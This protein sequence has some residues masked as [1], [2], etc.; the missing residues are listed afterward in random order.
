MNPPHDVAAIDVRLLV[1]NVGGM[2]ATR[3]PSVVAQEPDCDIYGFVETMLTEEN[4]GEVQGLL[5]GYDARHCVRPRP[6]RGRPH[7]G[8]TVFVKRF[9]PLNMGTG[10]TV[11]PDPRAGILWVVVPGFRL[12]IA[13][14]YFS[15]PGSAVYASGVVDADPMAALFAGLWAAEARGHKHLVLG[16]LNMRIGRLSYIHTCYTFSCDVPSNLAVPPGLNDPSVLPTLHHLRYV[17]SYRRSMDVQVPCRARALDFMN[18]LFAVS[19]VV[20]NGRTP[21]DMDGEVTCV[22]ERSG[23]V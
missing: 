18:G 2:A 8:I 5:P 21:G 19:S 23:D 17:P 7:G 3:I 4:V 11:D 20:L 16:D 12:T 14:C 9:S 13:V 10:L 6:S 15:P 22:R 1:Q